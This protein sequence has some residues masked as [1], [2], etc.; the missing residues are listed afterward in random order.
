MNS[1]WLASYVSLWLLVLMLVAIVYFLA[2]QLGLVYVRIGAG[3]RITR[4]G[5][6]INRPA[7]KAT[8]T[9]MAGRTFDIGGKRSRR[10]ILVFIAPGCRACSDLMP[11]VRALA[12]SE[13]HSLDVLLVGRGSESDIEAFAARHLLQHIPLSISS[14]LHDSYGVLGTPYAVLIG[15][16]GHILTK[17]MTNDLTHLESLLNAADLH[18]PSLEVHLSASGSMAGARFQ[19]K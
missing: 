2:R 18:V 9:D 3:A 10:L 16:C 4:V 6:E 7:P 15:E 5:P 1:L 8:V 19:K 13:H 12:R 11:A 14:E 17:G